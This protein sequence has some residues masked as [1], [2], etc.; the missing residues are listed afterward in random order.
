MFQ[1]NKFRAHN[2]SIQRLLFQVI[3]KCVLLEKW[4]VTSFDIFSTNNYEGPD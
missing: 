4:N 1:I 2:A 3:P